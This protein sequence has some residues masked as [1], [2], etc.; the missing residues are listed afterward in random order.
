MLKDWFIFRRLEA[1]NTRRNTVRRT[2]WYLNRAD[3]KLM[4]IAKEKLYFL[5]LNSVE[6]KSSNC[7]IFRPNS[8][9]NLS[10]VMLQTNRKTTCFKFPAGGLSSSLNA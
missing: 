4:L 5:F 7:V 9:F 3:S 8:S 6:I 1:L 10:S 2:V